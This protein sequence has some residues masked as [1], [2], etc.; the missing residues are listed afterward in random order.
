MISVAAIAAAAAAVNV[1]FLL[2]RSTT[3][4]TY[5]ARAEYSLQNRPGHFYSQ[6]SYIYS[7]SFFSESCALAGLDRALAYVVINGGVPT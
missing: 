3:K 4:S 6:F 2:S 1:V 5:Y 7:R